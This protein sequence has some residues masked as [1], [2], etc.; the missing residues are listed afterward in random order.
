AAMSERGF[1]ASRDRSPDMER[2][3]AS[4][5]AGGVAEPGG[6]G[7]IFGSGSG[8]DINAF[9]DASETGGGESHGIGHSAGEAVDT[10]KEQLASATTRAS[11]IAGKGVDSAASGLNKAADKLRDMSSSEGTQGKA[12]TA[13]VKAADTLDSASRFLQH[14]DTGTWV[15]DVQSI[16][17]QH[18]TQS[19]LVAAGAGFLLSKL[20]K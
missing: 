6:V 10:V 5:M 9:A 17:R 18:P 4:G 12:S 14:A 13:A 16:V 2:S 15:D 11:E 7:A 3:A 19:L 1:G 8:A 20:G